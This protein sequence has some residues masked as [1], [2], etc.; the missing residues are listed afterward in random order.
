M[1]VLRWRDFCVK[2]EKQAHRWTLVGMCAENPR[3]SNVNSIL[4]QGVTYIGGQW[5]F[6]QTGGGASPNLIANVKRISENGR[7]VYRYLARSAVA[8][9]D[10][11]VPRAGISTIYRETGH[12]EGQKFAI[13]AVAA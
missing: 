10:I 5:R 13:P 2:N 4:V 6:L 12:A 1:D 9:P 8:T 7:K 11:R 3:N